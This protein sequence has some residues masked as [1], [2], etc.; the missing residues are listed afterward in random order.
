MAKEEP[1]SVSRDLL[2]LQR[3]LCFLLES[4]QNNSKVVAFMKSPVG[5]YLDRHPFLALTVLM[6]VTMSAIPVGGFLL[7]V[8]LTSLGALMGAILLEG[9][10]ISVCGLSLLCI[11]CGLGF[12]SLAMSGIA[13]VSYL[14]VSCLMSY[15][16]SLRPLT[17]KNAN[18]D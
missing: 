17:Q 3:K 10:V 7:L 13:M 11:L 8:V 9:L 4:F 18:V 16:F 1:T 2:E 6:F 15:W 14:V 5:C 12:V